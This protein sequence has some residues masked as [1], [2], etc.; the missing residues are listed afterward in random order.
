ML[1][2]PLETETAE[3]WDHCLD[4]ESLDSVRVIGDLE[5]TSFALIGLETTDKRGNPNR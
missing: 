1:L 4:A 5:L 2:R 3:F